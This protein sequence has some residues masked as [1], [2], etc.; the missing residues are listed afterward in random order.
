MKRIIVSS[1]LGF[2]VFGLM[3]DVH[4]VSFQSIGPA[5][6]YMTQDAILFLPPVVSGDGSTVAANSGNQGF[7]WTATGGNVPLPGNRPSVAI[8][9]SYD[10]SVVAGGSRE[11]DGYWHPATWY[12][13]TRSILNAYPHIDLTRGTGLSA[14]GQ[15]VVGTKGRTG[16]AFKWTDGAVWDI[17]GSQLNTAMG[18]SADG[19]IIAGN[20]FE[21]VY[22]SDWDPVGT[23]VPSAR[24][25]NKWVLTELGSLTDDAYAGSYTFGISPDGN[26]VFGYSTSAR[27]RFRDGGWITTAG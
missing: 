15:V 6:K 3:S 21:T 23:S 27:A 8:A 9:L 16:Q 14:D 7:T 20:R 17:P 26:V 2:V 5:T 4:A 22:A 10:G 24:I 25:W 18:V 12:A 13:G 19:M 11:N 1:A